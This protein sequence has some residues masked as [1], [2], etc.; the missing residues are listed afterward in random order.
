MPKQ[1]I[2]HSTPPQVDEIRFDLVVGWQRDCDVQV[3]IETANQVDGQHH[4]VDHVYG[5]PECLA[6]IGELLVQK[7]AETGWKIERDSSK[8]APFG[9]SGAALGRLVLDSVTGSSPFGTGVWWHP[10]RHMI[11]DLIRT[12]RKARDAAFGTDA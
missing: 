2:N 7:L 6:A 5:D 11:N 12:L 1:R 10:S 4:L 9:A 3:G 8:P